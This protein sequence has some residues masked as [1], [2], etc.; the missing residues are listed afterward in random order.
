MKVKFVVI[1]CHIK[2]SQN[3]DN[4]KDRDARA[5]RML[6]RKKLRE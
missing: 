3:S 4:L 1:P 5:N 2:H 6:H